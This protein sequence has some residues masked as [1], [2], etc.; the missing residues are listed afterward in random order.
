MRV[1]TEERRQTILE[2]ARKEF[3]EHGF[4]QTS[5]TQI[6]RRVGGS[7]ATLYNYFDSKEAIFA[8]VME[9]SATERISE[10]FVNVSADKPLK[11]TLR[12]F[13]T[14]Y[15]ASILSPDLSAIH[16]MAISEADRSEIGRHFYN[17]GP[18]IGW[19]KISQYLRSLMDKSI[20]AESD[21]WIA[22]LQL[23]GLLEAELVEPYHLGVIETP[24]ENEIKLVVD[25]A[26]NAFLTLYPETKK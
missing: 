18:K 19:T 26:I 22:A 8:A 25:R 20:I 13:G 3:T 10:A 15:L 12:K 9:S 21:T 17:N 4:E 24:D 7:K 6:A 11:D 14:N 5:M 1:K 2:I 23:R 16:K